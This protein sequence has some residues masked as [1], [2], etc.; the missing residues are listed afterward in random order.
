MIPQQFVESLQARGVTLSVVNNRLRLDPGV[1]WKALTPDE[2]H[3]L[4]D[5]RAAIKRL[6][7]GSGARTRGRARTRSRTG[8]TNTRTRGLESGL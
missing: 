7:D 1:A 2:V 5:H 4:K 6:A 8:R 3:C